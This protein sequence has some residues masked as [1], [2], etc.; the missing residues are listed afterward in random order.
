MKKKINDIDISKI[1]K[2]KNI[3]QNKN[4]LKMGSTDS[5]KNSK[6]KKK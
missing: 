3:V 5:K 6:D 4:K 2:K 1:N